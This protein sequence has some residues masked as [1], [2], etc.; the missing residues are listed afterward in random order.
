M[1]EIIFRGLT[2][3]GKLVEDE[4][5]KDGK[6]VEG[7]LMHYGTDCFIWPPEMPSTRK[8]HPETVGQYTGLKDKNGKRMFAGDRVEDN[9]GRIWIIKYSKEKMSYMFAYEKDTRQTQ[10]FTRFNQE[11]LPLTVI[12]NI[13][14]E[15]P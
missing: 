2:K 14:E 11:Q 6:W 3:D 15:K 8:V 5:I 13:H 1:R 7:D 10:P 9:V 12:G 4:M